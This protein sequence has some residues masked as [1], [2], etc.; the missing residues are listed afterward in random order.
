MDSSQN[1]YEHFYLRQVL[2]RGH[3]STTCR[4][5]CQERLTTAPRSPTTRLS[6]QR[7]APM[8]TRLMLLFEASRQAFFLWPGR[9]MGATNISLRQ[10]SLKDWEKVVRSFSSSLDA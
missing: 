1:V 9:S 3:G 5:C 10:S 4:Q 2:D 7:L 8:S 6:L